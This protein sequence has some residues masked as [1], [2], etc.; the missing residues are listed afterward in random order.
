MSGHTA[1]VAAP[2]PNSFRLVLTLALAGLFSGLLIVSVYQVTLGPITAHREASLRRAVLE[3]VPG[4]TRMQPLVWAD[5][6][7]VPEADPDPGA[8]VIYAGYDDGGAFQ[9]YAVTGSGPGFQDNIALIFGYRPAERTT[10]GL[11]IL[12]SRET[13]GLGDK[14]YKDESWVA[15]FRS[16]AVDPQVEAVKDG[17]I[18]RLRNGSGDC[19]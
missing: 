15:A 2:A 7:L 9:G 5:G 11:V 12:E 18:S 1:P 6:V 4:S 14:I 10:S 16:L 8:E 3:V 17:G 19:G 13:P